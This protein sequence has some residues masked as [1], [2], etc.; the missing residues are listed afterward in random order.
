MRGA[1]YAEGLKAWLNDRAI[2]H[3]IQWSLEE[4]FA[5]ELAIAPDKYDEVRSEWVDMPGVK[6]G[7]HCHRIHVPAAGVIPRSMIPLGD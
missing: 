5:P 6:V 4:E 2:R 1:S 7:N 3:F